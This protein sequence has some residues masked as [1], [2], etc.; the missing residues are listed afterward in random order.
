MM[1]AAIVLAAVASFATPSP[2]DLA[3]INLSETIA[4]RVGDSV[5]PQWSKTPF[6]IDLLTDH[7][8]ALIGLTMPS[9]PPSF[10]TNL[11]ATFPLYNGIE[12]I[13]IGEPQFTQA[14]TP[15]RWSVTL[16]HEHFHAWQYSWPRYFPA[17][18]ALDVGPK[19]PNGMW[20][21][22][23]PFPYSDARVNAKYAAGASALAQAVRSIGTPA[24]RAKT[25]LYLSARRSFARA[26]APRDYNYFA[27]QCWQEGVAR[28]TEFTI[29][30]AAVQ[31]HAA[32]GSFLTDTQ[33]Q[34]LQMDAQSTYGGILRELNTPLREGERVNFYAFGAAEA[35][36][37]DRL[38]PNW[39]ANY[40]GAAFDL[41]KLLT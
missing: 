6:A 15:V 37:L 24:F 2:S 22:N 17:V 36:L 13:V 7:G 30:R 11:E 39:R 5:W 14:K 41:G 26:L 33:A 18:T 20:M 32:D 12:T 3:N 38:H 10:P 19:D 40:L 28:Y 34:A 9:P 23:Y 35:L 4:A 31:A 25:A 1:I 29:A 16:L 8:S 21:L 27:F